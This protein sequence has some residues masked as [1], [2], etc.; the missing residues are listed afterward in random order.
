MDYKSKRDVC[1]T[2]SQMKVHKRSS[3][4]IQHLTSD[5]ESR[6]GKEKFPAKNEIKKDHDLSVKKEEDEDVALKANDDD[7]V[8]SALS[9]KLEQNYMQVF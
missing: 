2:E 4:T 7:K 5:E 3:S 8:S 9:L 6:E 1:L